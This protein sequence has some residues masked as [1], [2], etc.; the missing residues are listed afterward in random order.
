MGFLLDHWTVV[1]STLE[2]PAKTGDPLACFNCVDAQ[3]ISCLVQNPDDEHLIHLK[4]KD[5]P[6]K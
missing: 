5:T 1:R 4:R 2:C 3:V 6:W